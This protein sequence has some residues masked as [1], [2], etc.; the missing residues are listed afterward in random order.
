MIHRIKLNKKGECD[1]CMDN[2][3]DDLEDIDN[4]LENYDTLSEDG[5]EFDY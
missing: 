2:L 4:S 3:D 1:V 5:E